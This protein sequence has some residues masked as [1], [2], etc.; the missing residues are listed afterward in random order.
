M[1]NKYEVQES[2]N[3]YHTKEL[4]FRVK[5]IY[6]SG[7]IDYTVMNSEELK[8]LGIKIEKDED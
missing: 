5:V 3:H 2:F 7:G 8:S 4:L 6:E 1:M